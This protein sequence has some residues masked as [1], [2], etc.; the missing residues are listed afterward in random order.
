MIIVIVMS[1]GLGIRDKLVNGLSS[2]DNTGYYSRPLLTLTRGGGG[3]TLS[4]TRQ[5]HT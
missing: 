3:S 2:E 5:G 4:E 1:P